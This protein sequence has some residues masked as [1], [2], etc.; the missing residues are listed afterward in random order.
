MTNTHRVVPIS[1]QFC[2][3]QSNKMALDVQRLRLTDDHTLESASEVMSQLQ[4]DRRLP[5]GRE[6]CES[7]LRDLGFRGNQDRRDGEEHTQFVFQGG[8][9]GDLRCCGAANFFGAVLR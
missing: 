5:N 2:V 9:H 6:S 4:F 7:L 8:G 3:Q 1:N